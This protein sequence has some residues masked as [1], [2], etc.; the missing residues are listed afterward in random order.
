MPQLPGIAVAF[1][2]CLLLAA[3]SRRAKM[4]PL[5]IA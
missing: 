4:S 2:T 5:L 3:L 1:A